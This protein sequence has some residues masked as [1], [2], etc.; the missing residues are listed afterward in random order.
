MARIL[1]ARPLMPRIHSLDHAAGI[2]VFRC[3]HRR[4]QRAKPANISTAAF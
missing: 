2:A 1:A 4:K 3:P